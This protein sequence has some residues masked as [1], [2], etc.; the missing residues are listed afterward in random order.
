MKTLTD[1]AK[2]APEQL[3]REAQA[4]VRRLTSGSATQRDAQAFRRWRATSPLHAEAFAEAQRWWRSLDPALTRVVARNE[5]LAAR[6]GAHGRRPAMGRRTFLAGAAG[7][8]AVA[9]GAAVLAPVDF[10]Q[11]LDAWQADYRTA[12]GEQRQ[13]ALTDHVNV[14]MNTLTSIASREAD[15]HV[16]GMELIAGEAAIDMSAAAT[17]FTVSAG[18]GR[19]VAA[20]GH[21]QVRYTGASVC[22]TCVDGSLRVE[23]PLGVRTLAGREQIRYDRHT[24]G[25]VVRT[26]VNAL[27]AWRNGVLVFRQTPLAQVIDEINRYR[28]GQVVLLDRHAGRREVNGRFAIGML[29]TVLVEIQHTYGLQAHRLPGGVLL[30]G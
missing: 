1:P 13:I 11:R 17:P 9:A 29:D 3:Q 5:T 15:G 22:V 27:S 28:P 19:S 23:H 25:E 20:G 4:W 24:L 6:L 14:E 26:D 8:A 7:L 12:A 16:V 2:I 10:R 18:V 30:L 21:F